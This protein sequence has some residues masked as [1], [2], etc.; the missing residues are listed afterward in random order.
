MIKNYLK[1]AWR[2]LKKDK[3]FTLLNVLGLSAGLAC[4]LLI[5]LWVHDELR[6]DQFF[7]KDDQVYQV[8]EHRKSSSQ[9]LTDESSGMMSEVLKLQNSE[10]EYAAAVA[11]SDWFQKF[12]L[13]SGDKNIKAAGQYTGKDYFN[14]F[15][16]KMLQGDRGKVL[17]NKNGIV[18]SDDLAKRLFNTSDNAIGKPV[19][20][21]QGKYFY[22]SG[23]F[24]KLPVHSSQQFDFVLSFDYLADV[25]GWVKN[26]GDAGPHNFIMLKKGTDINTFNKKIAGMVTKNNGDTTRS[27]FVTRFSYNYLHNT[28]NHGSRVGDRLAYV[29]L[30]SLI[31]IFI[32]IIACINFMNLSTAKASGRMKEVGI[33]KVVGAARGQLITQFLSESLLMA[34]LTMLIAI[35]V[36]WLLL[37]QFNQLTGKQIRL[38]FDAPLLM[39]LIAI[40]LFTGLA[41]GSYPALY[42]S[43]FK[44]LA[45]LKGKLSSSFAELLARNGLV[46]FQF[47]LSVM[48]IVAVLVVYKQIQ[49]IQSTKPGYDKDN[50]IRFDSEGKLQGNEDNFTAQLKNIPGVINASFTQHGLVGRNYGTAVV[51]WEGNTN[52]DIYFEGFYGGYNF[53][54][55]LGMKMAAGRAFSKNYG[56]EGG[57]VILNETAIEAM[58]LKNPVGKNIKLF[59][60]SLQ[61]I[62]VV[63]DFHFESL[64]EAVRPSFIVLAQDVNP[65]YKLIVRIKGTQQKQTIAQIQHLYEAYNPGFPFSCNFLDDAYQKQYE[66]ETRVS[67]LAKYFSFLAILISCLGLFGLVAFTA[68]KRQKEIGV[69]KV[70]GASVNSITIMLT[71]DFLKLVLIAVLVAFPIAWWVMYQ[72]LQG[73]AYR[74]SIG[75]GVF[76]IAGTS[77][78]FITLLTVSFQAIKAA[79]AN[80]VKSLRS[81]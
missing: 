9:Q 51:S 45:I 19:K 63:K 64:H 69:R 50:V 3:Q 57:K 53:I 81:E 10:V 73:F 35:A 26:W 60:K 70:I 21:Q 54:E 27:A 31:A 58:H 56:T 38:E 76:I 16:F 46:V 71:K 59:N 74:I 34:L 1:I 52:Q 12:T 30:F 43:K 41:S 79:T 42:L 75:P 24:E 72:W 22:V 32:L 39:M 18:I 23:V 77:I 36:T 8:L 40:T 25:Q 37:P 5:Y 48:L 6:Y 65:W 61:V 33:K 11:P 15:S 68:Q 13:T 49:Y 62:G 44:P 4:T 17:N 80:P 28:F 2:N 29:K 7:D 47:T 66:T 20:F 67:I 78:I 14:I 55:T